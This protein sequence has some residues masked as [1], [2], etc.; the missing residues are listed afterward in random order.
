MKQNSLNVVGR[1]HRGKLVNA[2]KE[3]KP[4]SIVAVVLSFTLQT[5]HK[6]SGPV[7]QY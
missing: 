2:S 7:K 3:F 1:G 5:K 6:Q 4:P